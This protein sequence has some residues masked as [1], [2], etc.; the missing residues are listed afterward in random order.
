MNNKYFIDLFEHFQSGG[1]NGFEVEEGDEDIGKNGDGEGDGNDS[2]GSSIKDRLKGLI[3]NFKENPLLLIPIIIVVVLIAVYVYFIAEIIIPATDLP[4]LI[5]KGG[6]LED[7]IKDFIIVVINNGDTS[8]VNSSEITLPS[9]IGT[10]SYLFPN[11]VETE[12]YNY[13]SVVNDKIKELEEVWG[14]KVLDEENKDGDKIQGYTNYKITE[15]NS[16]STETDYEEIKTC[17][18]GKILSINDDVMSEL[19][20]LSEDEKIKA[21]DEAKDDILD[22]SLEDCG[23][24]TSDSTTVAAAGDAAAGGL[25]RRRHREPLQPPLPG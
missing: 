11:N 25:A 3:T 17:L 20:L 16:V 14:D 9:P 18:E 2:S 19:K 10:P 13:L 24:V 21:L 7:N 12:Y 8:S 4:G 6:I 15:G 5:S 23:L 1:K 22:I